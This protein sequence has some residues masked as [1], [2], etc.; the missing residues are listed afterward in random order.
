MTTKVHI[1]LRSFLIFLI[2]FISNQAY[3]LNSSSYLVANSA[4]KLFDFDKAKDSYDLLQTDLNES[5]LHNKLL[6]YVNLNFITKANIIAKKI[7][8]INE[9]NQEAWIVN[10][11]YAVIT[12]NLSA[13]RSFQSVQKKSNM[14]L[15]NYIF[16]LSNGDIKKKNFIAR[17]I[18]EVVY[19]STSENQ[20]EI[21]YEF[22]LFYLS[23]STFLNPDFNEAYFYTAKIYQLLQSYSKA[24]IFYNKVSASHNL[25][26]DSQKNIAINKS[27]IGLHSE[28]VLF[29]KKLIENNQSNLNLIFALA[30]LYRVNQDYDDAIT[31]Y[32]KFINLKNDSFN[33]YW[34]IFYFRG[35]CFERLKDWNLAEK[36]FLH[37]LQIKPNSP[38][39]LNYLAYGWLERD[40]YL[41]KAIE[42][43]KEAYEANP[44]DSYIADSLAWAFFKKNDLKKAS[45]LMERV[46]IMAPGEAVSLDHL[47]DIYYAMKRKREATYYWKQAL[48]LVEPEDEIKEKLIKKLELYYAG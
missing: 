15:V 33:E 26:V 1:F 16:F 46:I 2:F 21:N 34:K 38:Q 28:G 7:I 9:F 5:G 29:L 45:A 25:F 40:L 10:L 35:I 47:G 36:D 17:S 4:I 27:K 43:L 8:K 44:N 37:S 22:L 23:I 19:A 13:F 39:V 31:Y 12:N 32:S 30:D 24:E 42:M 18:L 48:D 3:S 20:K 14:D 11:S 41:D 6:A